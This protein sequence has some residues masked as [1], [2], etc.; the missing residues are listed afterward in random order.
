MKKRPGRQSTVDYML[1]V[2]VKSSVLILT[3]YSKLY[4]QAYRHSSSKYYR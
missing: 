1:N 3:V 4:K 2:V